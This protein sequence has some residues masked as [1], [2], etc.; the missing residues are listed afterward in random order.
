M[1]RNNINK[2]GVKYFFIITENSTNIKSMSKH[3]KNFLY[4]LFNELN[5]SNYL[6]LINI[7]SSTYQN[8]S[9]LHFK[10]NLHNIYSV[11]LFLIILLI[12]IFT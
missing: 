10:F 1:V 2:N 12:T 11:I 9:G 7:Y 5:T 4:T 3:S 6:S 8:I